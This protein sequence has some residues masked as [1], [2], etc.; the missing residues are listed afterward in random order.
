V[1]QVVKM[2]RL[3]LY[4]QGLFC[5]AQAIRWE[6]EDLNVEPLPSLRTINRILARNDLTH[7]RTGRYESKGKKYPTLSGKSIN[8]VH[9]ADFLG[10]CY[11]GEATRFYSL[12]IIDLASGRCA[13]EVLIQRGAQHTIEGFWS[14]WSRLGLPEHLQVDNE[15]VFYGSPTHPRGMGPLIRLCLL[16]NIELWFIPKGEPW[17]NG[18]VE[19][20]NA[21]Y[22]QKFLK[23]VQIAGESELRQQ[24]LLFEQK[25]NSRYR[26]SKLKGRTPLEILAMANKTL[27]FALQEQAPH[28]PL[29]K[30]KT[31]KY[32]IVRFIRG[33]A[34]LDVFGETFRLPSETVY[35]Y[36]IA[37]ID[38][39]EQKLKIYLDQIQVDEIDYKMF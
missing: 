10:P 21:H 11:I 6:L 24:S 28:H 27:R 5:G 38:V 14:I 17:R 33:D 18:V 1:E 2:I 31:G 29:K 19:K 30:P 15:M 7:G 9:Q 37:T 22:R 34:L 13:V 12:N 4:N 32:H 3:S 20:F 8:R 36:V 26:Y 23:R 16:N 25:H 35:E 39:K